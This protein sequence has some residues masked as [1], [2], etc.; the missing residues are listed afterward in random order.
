MKWLFPVGLE[1]AEGLRALLSAPSLAPFHTPLLEIKGFFPVPKGQLP[2]PWVRAACVCAANILLGHEHDSRVKHLSEA[3]N[4]KRRPLAGEYR[5][6]A[7]GQPGSA[8]E[9]A[10]GCLLCSEDGPGLWPGP[11]SRLLW[12]PGLPAS[13]DMGVHAWPLGPGQRSSC[14]SSSE[15][16]Q[17]GR[18]L[19]RGQGT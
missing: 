3:L 4:D 17:E 12:A 14:S 13:S 2:V 6:P 19:L 15:G 8:F 7:P 16:R 10:P 9:A 11:H 1:A 18:R 5:S